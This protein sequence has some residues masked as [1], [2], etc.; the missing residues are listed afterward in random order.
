M[1]IFTRGGLS[2]IIIIAA[3]A[4]GKKF[5]YIAGQIGVMSLTGALV[6][7]CMYLEN[8]GDPEIMQCFSNGTPLG[9]S[10]LAFSSS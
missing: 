9:G 4:I 6:M 8:K 3:T 1:Q 7:V 10:C 5:P 2:V